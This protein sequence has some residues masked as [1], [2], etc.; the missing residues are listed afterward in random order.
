[1]LIELGRH[2]GNHLVRDRVAHEPFWWRIGQACAR[3]LPIVL[4]KVPFCALGLSLRCHQQAGLAAHVTIKIF[5]T[6]LFA[7]LSPGVKLGEAAD[8]AVVFE[9]FDWQPGQGG[10]LLLPLAYAIF[11]ASHDADS[12]CMMSLNRTLYLGVK[13][14]KVVRI[15]KGN[16]VH[17]PSE[18]AHRFRKMTH[19]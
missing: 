14:L 11:G 2:Q 8:K 9:Y 15:V 19:R 17:D 3:L 6:M 1:M 5:E 7:R 10:P 13:A 12:A 4:I 16:I 18:V